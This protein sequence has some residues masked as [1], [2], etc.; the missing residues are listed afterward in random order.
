MDYS[1]STPFMDFVVKEMDSILNLNVMG[2]QGVGACLAKLHWILKLWF[3][4]YWCYSV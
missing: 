2:G 4:T 1:S 3:I